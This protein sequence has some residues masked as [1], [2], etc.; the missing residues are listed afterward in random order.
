MKRCPNCGAE[1]ADAI[2]CPLCGAL[3]EDCAAPDVDDVNPYASGSQTTRAG[4]WGETPE[5]PSGFWHAVY[6]CFRKTFSI[7]GRASRSEFWYFWL[8]RFIGAF[9]FAFAFFAREFFE[10]REASFVFLLF[11]PVSIGA[12]LAFPI[13]G[14]LVLASAIAVDFGRSGLHMGIPARLRRASRDRCWNDL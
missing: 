4:E 9:G 7:K 8:A 3:V 1:I 12:F 11:V 14:A 13:G 5:I 2:G 6:L 10:R